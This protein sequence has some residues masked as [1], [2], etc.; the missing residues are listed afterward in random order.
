MD[1]TLD[2]LAEAEN[3]VVRALTAWRANKDLAPDQVHAVQNARGRALRIRSWL[4]D[5]G[6]LAPTKD[7]L[8]QTVLNDMHP[9]ATPGTVVE[10]DDKAFRLCEFPASW[11]GQTVVQWTRAWLEQRIG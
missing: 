4:L 8:V 6:R 7:D 5:S 10:F 3:E 9:H 11:A 2:D 1:Y